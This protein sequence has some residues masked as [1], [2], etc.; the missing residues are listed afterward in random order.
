MAAVLANWGGYYRQGVYLTEAR[1]MGLSVR[2]PDVNFAQREFSLSYINA[3]PVLFMGLDQV[4]DLTRRTQKRIIRLRPFSSVTDFLIRVDPRSVEAENL[5]KVGA[6]A[7]WGTIP[8]LLGQLDTGGWQR[9]QLPLFEMAEMYAPEGETGYVQEGDWSLEEKVAA[10]KTIL[11]ASLEAHPLELVRESIIK[12]GALSTV[13]AVTRIGERVRV[14][15]MRQTWRRGSTSKGE[16][17]YVMALEDLEGMLNVIIYADVHQ[18]SRGV[19]SGSGPYIVE[20]DVEVDQRI[21]EPY[22][23]A[24]R[25]WRL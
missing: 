17:L 10:Q 8:Q 18:R 23:R 3:E 6:L 7:G 2:P 1:R 22:L 14:A 20:G 16:R 21:G 15:G 13:E 24:E 19:I 11:G 12:A 5:V 25:I 9:G 4:R